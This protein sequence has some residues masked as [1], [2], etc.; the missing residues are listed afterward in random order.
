MSDYEGTPEEWE[1]IKMPELFRK[2]YFRIDDMDLKLK[3]SSVL[4]PKKFVKAFDYFL[5]VSTR[6]IVENYNLDFECTADNYD[7]LTDIHND[8][9]NRARKGFPFLRSTTPSRTSGEIDKQ[10]IN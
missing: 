5:F 7:K 9:V 8:I 2:Y 3:E 10:G 1:N 6:L 4:L